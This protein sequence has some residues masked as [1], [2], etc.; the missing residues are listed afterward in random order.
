MKIFVLLKKKYISI[1]FLLFTVLLVVFANSNLT[2]AK[3]GLQLWAN[4]VVPSLFPFFVAVELLNNTNL[5]YYLSKYLDTYMRP[6]FNLPGIATFP[7]I[8]GIISGFPVGAKIVSNLYSSGA[9]TKEEADR[10]LILSNNSGPLFVIGTVGYAFYGSS[11]VGVLLLVTHILASLSVGVLIGLFSRI[12]KLS[13]SSTYDNSS[14]S[15]YTIQRHKDI[16][17]SELGGILGSS[18]TSAIKSI[19]VIG[20]FVV[21]FSVIISMLNRTHLLSI[22]ANFISTIIPVNANL[23]SSFFTGI[24]E[25]TNGLSIIASVPLKDMSLKLALSAFVLGFGGISVTLQVLSII[26]KDKLSIKKYVL[27]R[28]FVGVVASVYTFILFSM[29][30]FNLNI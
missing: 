6:I 15:N 22:V 17:I 8:M 28:I 3:K 4:N 5:V 1:L 2:S 20:G 7:L 9:C 23:I 11:T 18:I 12:H 16:G 14:S 24:I 19:L 25:F 10:M 26:S 27:G 21:I 30:M 29:P 13:K